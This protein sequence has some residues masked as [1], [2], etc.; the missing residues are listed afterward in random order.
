LAGDPGA[1]QFVNSQAGAEVPATSTRRRRRRKGKGNLLARLP[2][3]VL[4]QAGVVVVIV[5][6]LMLK[7]A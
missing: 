2:A 7:L 5:A 1:A 4:I 3:R 6:L